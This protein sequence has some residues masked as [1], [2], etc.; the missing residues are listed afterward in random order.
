[1]TPAFDDE[2]CRPVKPHWPALDGL[3]EGAEKRGFSSSQLSRLRQAIPVLWTKAAREAEAALA[4]GDP[5]P[6]PAGARF[7]QQLRAA[8]LE[9]WAERQLEYFQHFCV[10]V[11]VKAVWWTFN[12]GLLEQAKERNKVDAEPKRPT[13]RARSEAGVRG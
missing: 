3:V 10:L 12:G 11:H 6:A 8:V 13:R 1:M 9:G 2:D 7:G 5:P 4:R